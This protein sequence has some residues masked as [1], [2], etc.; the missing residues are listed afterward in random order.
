MGLPIQFGPIEIRLY[1]IEGRAVKRV[2]FISDDIYIVIYRVPLTSPTYLF[3]LTVRYPTTQ[4]R[5]LSRPGG[6]VDFGH[7]LSPAKL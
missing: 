5:H 1:E 6:S 2:N 3:T 4:C 7:S